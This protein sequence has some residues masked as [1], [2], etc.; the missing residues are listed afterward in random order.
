MPTTH[1]SEWVKAKDVTVDAYYASE[2]REGGVR[3]LGVGVPGLSRSQLSVF[4]KEQWEQQKN[5][6]IY[7]TWVREAKSRIKESRAP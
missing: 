1:I 7:E 5:R 3:A 4:T 6:L 2:D